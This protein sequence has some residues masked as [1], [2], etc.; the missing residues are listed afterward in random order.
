MWSPC[1]V[2]PDGEIPKKAEFWKIGSP[3]RFVIFPG[4]KNFK[5]KTP[6]TKFFFLPPDT[7]S[8][9]FFRYISNKKNPRKK[10]R[11]KTPGKKRGRL[12]KKFFLV[13]FSFKL[14]DPGN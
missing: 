7:F 5:E 4:S 12:K 10:T 11:K 1:S 13:F 8:P 3:V 2:S 14:L 6:Q 9:F